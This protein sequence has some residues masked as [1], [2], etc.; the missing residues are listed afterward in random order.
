MIPLA[1]TALLLPILAAAPTPSG[2]RGATRLDL[3][4]HTCVEP[5]T[6]AMLR[7]AAEARAPQHG[8]PAPEGAPATYTFY[9]QAGN[10]GGD[11]LPPGFVDIDP[12]PRAFAD[13]TCNHY[14]YD[15]HAGIDTGI[16]NFDMQAIGIPVFAALDGEVI[17]ATDGEP[18]MNLECIGAGN[19]IGIDHG[20]THLSWYYHL[21]NGSVAV[22]VGQQVVAGQQIAL[23]ASSGCSFGPHLHF[24]TWFNDQVV[25][26]FAGPCRPGAS[27]W[28]AQPPLNEDNRLVDFGFT[29]TDLEGV[30]GLPFAMPTDAQI[31]I[32][33]SGVF[34]WVQ[35]V[36]LPERATW[37]VR[38][39]TPNDELIED[40]GEVPFDNDTLWRYA[41]FWWGYDLPELHA[42]T[43][44][45][46]MEL[47]FSGKVMIDAPLD[48]VAQPDPAFNRPPEPIALTLD[49]PT[50][51]PGDVISCRVESSLT[52][53]DLDWDL[54]RYR[55][56][57]DVEGAVVRDVVTAAMSDVI[58][59]DTAAPGQ[60]LT[61]TVTPSDGKSDGPTAQVSHTF[62]PPCP[63][64]LTGDG[65]VNSADLNT[66]LAAFGAS[67]AGD[68]DEDGDTD[69]AD[70]NTVLAQFGTG[71]P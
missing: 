3:R 71:C 21:A 17:W 31:P 34:F 43:G 63:A 35:T 68:T 25:E 39:F 2:L 28:T 30:A 40:S 27:G 15:G 56:V 64:D 22:E 45:F 14:T 66:I 23:A 58:P 26:P 13:Y 51:A 37:R 32:D 4:T 48:I 50:P 10:W 36:N 47:S 1:T 46:R 41:W 59:R 60:T 16:R 42:E 6:R 20:G 29:T 55:Y 61:C 5:E 54:V 53:D 12:K 49:P 65:Q 24:E 33:H 11:L 57:W 7:A 52:M 44:T 69:S 9:P 38:W 19:I 62:T 70:L 18:D 67:D 8:A